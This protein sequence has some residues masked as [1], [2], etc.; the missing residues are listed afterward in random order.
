MRQNKGRLSPELCRLN[1]LGLHCTEVLATADEIQRS[2]YIFSQQFR[3]T[4]YYETN[5]THKR[6][7]ASLNIQKQSF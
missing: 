4:D 1:G 6:R 7:M 3:P 5:R 2:L